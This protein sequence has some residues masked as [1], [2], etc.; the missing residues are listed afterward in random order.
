MKTEPRLRKKKDRW[1]IE[2]WVKGKTRYIMQLPPI[3]DLIK[4][5]KAPSYNGKE[6]PSQSTKEDKVNASDKFG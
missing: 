2:Q 5:L 1:V 3:P 4:I 6:T